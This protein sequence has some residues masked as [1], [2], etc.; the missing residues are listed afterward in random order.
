MVITEPNPVKVD[1]SN[2]V[3][4]H[5]NLDVSGGS[6]V[7]SISV[8]PTTDSTAVKVAGRQLTNSVVTDPTVSNPVGLTLDAAGSIDLGAT[9]AV[10]K[11]T[12]A[13]G[14]F[15]TL[16]LGIDPSVKPTKDNPVEV[17]FYTLWFGP[18]GQAGGENLDIFRTV[19]ITPEP[20][21][22]MLLAA[23]AAFFA[24]RRRA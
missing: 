4:L 18:G 15:M 9:A 10:G 20:A 24:R 14:P 7:D 6:T 16:T 3:V 19:Q 2:Q 17:T 8:F 1:A 21:S 22:M 13:S 11:S 5:F 23:G 12:D